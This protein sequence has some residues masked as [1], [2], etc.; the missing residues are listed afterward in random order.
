MGCLCPCLAVLPTGRG[1]NSHHR[2]VCSSV[3]TRPTLETH[4]GAPSTRLSLIPPVS[5]LGISLSCGPLVSSSLSDVPDVD[6]YNDYTS[7]TWIGS[8]CKNSNISDT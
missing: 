7:N 5:C 8:Y 4:P 6:M 3:S 2:V 1:D